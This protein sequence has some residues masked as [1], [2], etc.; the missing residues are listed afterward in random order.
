MTRAAPSITSSAIA[1]RSR[2][3]LSHAARAPCLC[4]SA[5]SRG[6]RTPRPTACCSPAASRPG[7][8]PRPARH[9]WPFSHPVLALG[10]I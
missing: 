8:D 2:P 1:R 7:T 10:G 9:H 5:T 3:T 4:R 6:S